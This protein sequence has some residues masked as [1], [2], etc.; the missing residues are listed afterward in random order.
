MLLVLRFDLDLFQISSG[1][2]FPSAQ[3]EAPSRQSPRQCRTLVHRQ[4]ER[5]HTSA[6]H[7]DRPTS[8]DLDQ[9]ESD[10]K[11]TCRSDVVP[12]GKPEQLRPS[13]P[14]F[15]RFADPAWLAD[16]LPKPVDKAATIRGRPETANHRL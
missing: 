2:K 14:R 15:L 1:A 11:N 13:V 6:R 10:S 4:T 12:T 8:S 5:K 7:V 9:I 16:R 3:S